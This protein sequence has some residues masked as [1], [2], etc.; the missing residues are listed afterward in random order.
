MSS[1][2]EPVR[3]EDKIRDIPD[4]PQ[5]GVLFKDITPLLQDAAT[6]RAA[7]E[8]LAAHYAGA[9]IQTV[10]GIESRGFILGAPLAYLLNCGFVPVRKFGKLPAQ[11]VSVEYAL[12]YG[13]NVVEI[14]RDAI[15][16]GERVLIVDDLLATG[17][18]VSAAIELIE[19]LSGHI[20]GIAFLV[21]LT[22]LKGREHLK[23]HDV[24]ALIK[25]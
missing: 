23:G 19:G 21:E 13:T 7:M 6:Y 18:T 4:F 24:F 20:A 14:H 2:S 12:E 5:K 16:P 22:F 9:G 3:L 15:K 11:T 8:R 10:V 25:Y 17:G 1:T